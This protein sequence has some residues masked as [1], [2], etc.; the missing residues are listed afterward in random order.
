MQKRLPPILLDEQDRQELNQVLQKGK[1]SVRKVKRAKV[2]LL[3]AAGEKVPLISAQVGVSEA[4]VYN[5]YHRYDPGKLSQALEES[6]RS[7]QP[8]KV[9]PLLEAE[10]TRIACSKAPEGK[11]RWTVNL[12]NQHLVELGHQLDDESVRLILKKAALNLGSKDN[13]DEPTTFRSGPSGR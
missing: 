9:T 1:Y 8:R 6:P 5:V 13:G 7:G 4:T 12:I 11:S 3:L 10:V 2:V